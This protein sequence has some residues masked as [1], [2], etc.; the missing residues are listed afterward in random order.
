[1]RVGA[2]RLDQDPSTYATRS[3]AAWFSHPAFVGSENNTGHDIS[4]V[5]LNAT[6][7]GARPAALPRHTGVCARVAG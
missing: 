7:S 4:L 1:M 6:V 2:W 3:I 5:L